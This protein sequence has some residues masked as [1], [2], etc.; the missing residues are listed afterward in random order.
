MRRAMIL[1]TAVM[2]LLLAACGG[3]EQP[4]VQPPEKT[5]P[6]EEKTEPTEGT[7]QAEAVKLTA[8]LEGKGEVPP[9]DPDG[10]GSATFN[11]NPSTGQVC[12]TISVENI[13]S[14]ITAAHIH[15]GEAGTA[16]PAVIPL[17]PPKEGPVDTCAEADPA[18]VQRVIA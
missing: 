2:A 12:Y 1:A 13:G 15:E 7:P 16:G 3:A 6:A 17:E 14:P 8:S 9:G 11:L 18:V 5:T 4:A 10:S